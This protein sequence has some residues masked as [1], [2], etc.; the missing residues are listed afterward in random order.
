MRIGLIPASFATK[1]FNE[2][3]KI[4]YKPGIAMALIILSASS[5]DRTMNMPG[6]DAT[7]KEKDIRKAIKL[8]EETNSILWADSI[9]PDPIIPEPVCKYF[10]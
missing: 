5:K 9:A 6:K 3:N 2:A 1:A 8:A 7:T 10:W 4:G